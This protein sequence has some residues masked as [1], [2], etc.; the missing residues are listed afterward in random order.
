MQ[1]KIKI[2]YNIIRQ[3]SKNITFNEFIKVISNSPFYHS[4]SL[5]SPELYTNIF[6]RKGFYKL[7]EIVIQFINNSKTNIKKELYSQI[8]NI[9]NIYDDYI[10][11]YLI[12]ETINDLIHE[13]IQTDVEPRESYLPDNIYSLINNINITDGG[14]IVRQLVRNEFNSRKAWYINKIKS[15]INETLENNIINSV[16]NNPEIFSLK[17]LKDLD[18]IGKIF[19]ID[20]QLINEI[21]DSAK[22]KFIWIENNFIDSSMGYGIN[23]G[24]MM[25]NYIRKRRGE[26]IDDK[27]KLYISNSRTPEDLSI[28]TTEEENKLPAAYGSFYFNKQVCIIEGR[29]LIERND[30]NYNKLLQELK[31][32]FKHVFDLTISNKQLKQE[33]KLALKI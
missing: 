11:N 20:T 32:R 6:G 13:Y 26:A 27:E 33:A 30:D 5:S 15:W 3:V 2:F 17:E 25:I 29:Y 16:S 21:N 1:E 18:D 31:K 19:N 10:N 9:I 8:S 4:H 22:D 14:K 12:N 28:K 23:H 24:Q 7:E